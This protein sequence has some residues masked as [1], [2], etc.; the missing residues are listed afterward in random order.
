MAAA[1]KI[2]MRCVREGTDFLLELSLWI[3][4]L[5]GLHGRKFLGDDMQRNSVDV[6]GLRRHS[7]FWE[8]L[9]FE[10]GLESPGNLE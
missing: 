1:G 2:L 8:R 4:D 3:Y 6:S 7:Q 9:S 10:R 5:F